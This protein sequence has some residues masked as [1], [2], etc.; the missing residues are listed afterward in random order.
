MWGSRASA[1]VGVEGLQHALLEDNPG[2]F[3]IL[4]DSK[5]KT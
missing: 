2:F 4:G 1:E 3:R 5:F